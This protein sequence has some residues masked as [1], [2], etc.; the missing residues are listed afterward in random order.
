M[1][2]GGRE[3][4][5]WVGDREGGGWVAGGIAGPELGEPGRATDS[6]SFMKPT[7]NSLSKPR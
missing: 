6:Q 5:G 4:D 7:E 3:V 1:G 2:A